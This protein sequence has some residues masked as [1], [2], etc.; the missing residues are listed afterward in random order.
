MSA[1]RELADYRE[2][3]REICAVCAKPFGKDARAARR[4]A[5]NILAKWGY[6]NPKGVEAENGG[7]RK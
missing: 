3:L 7:A 1:E 4:I 2:A 5:S 6:V